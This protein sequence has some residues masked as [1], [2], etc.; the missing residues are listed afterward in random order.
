[1]LRVET[2]MMMI[3]LSQHKAGPHSLSHCFVADT[4]TFQ[5]VA[6]CSGHRSGGDGQ[7]WIVPI[8]ESGSGGEEPKLRLPTAAT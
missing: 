8:E 2:L 4:E 6:R 5:N 1:V 3:V 7:Q